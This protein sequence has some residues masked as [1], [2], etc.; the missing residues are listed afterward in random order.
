MYN[1]ICTLQVGF[2]LGVVVI[3]KWIRIFLSTCGYEHDLGLL[4]TTLWITTQIIHK[5]VEAREN[6]NLIKRN[7]QGTVLFQ[8]VYVYVSFIIVCFMLYSGHS[9]YMYLTNYVTFRAL[10]V[11]IVCIGIYLSSSTSF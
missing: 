8:C 4:S 9:S 11:W 10:I 7:I 1:C 3:Y 5:F 2:V 6:T